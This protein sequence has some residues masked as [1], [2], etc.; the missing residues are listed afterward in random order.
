MDRKKLTMAL[1]C[2]MFFFLNFKVINPKEISHLEKV[3]NV[4]LNYVFCEANIKREKVKKEKPK[5][6]A[7]KVVTPLSNISNDSIVRFAMQL[8][9][10]V[11]KKYKTNAI[12]QTAQFIVE[13][14]LGKSRIAKRGNNFFGIKCHVK[15][16]TSSYWKGK[17]I[18]ADD[19]EKGECFRKYETISQSF[20]DYGYFI[21]SNSRYSKCLNQK[22]SKKVIT[23]LK[24]ANYATSN[25]YV[26]VILL[27]I[28]QYRLEEIY[29]NLINQQENERVDSNRAIVIHTDSL[30]QRDFH[31][32]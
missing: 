1:L 23:E 32:D 25:D 19:D 20:S 16:S 24:K 17:Q 6:F 13:S 5:H 7:E 10:D 26:A 18:Y 30:L 3:N 31:M 29:N 28:K 21:S 12:V 11:E 4:Y 14:N 8:A 2:V 22:N 9:I 15:K 27:T